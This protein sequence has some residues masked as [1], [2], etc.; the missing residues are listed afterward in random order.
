MNDKDYQRK[1]QREYYAKNKAKRQ[2]Q[3]RQWRKENPDKVRSI[4]KKW[5]DANRDKQRENQEKWKNTL[6]GCLCTKLCHLKKQK[7]NRVLDFEIDKD[8]LLDL[9]KSQ[10]GCCAISSYPMQTTMNSLF[11][12]S[13]DRIDSS[14]GYTKNNI[15]LVCQGINF[16]KN[17]YTNEEM[18]EFW[19]YRNHMR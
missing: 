1:Y 3:T 19:E 7:R 14:L 9:W 18:I 15:Q 6:S 17:H 2:E 13:V 12:V 16:A 4:R 10:E 8:D 11:A 5:Y